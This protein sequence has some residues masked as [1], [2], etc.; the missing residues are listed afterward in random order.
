MHIYA[1]V[2]NT[3]FL[4]GVAYYLQV[5]SNKQAPNCKAL[6]WLHIHTEFQDS[7]LSCANYK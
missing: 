6:K 1:S 7:A 3:T 5:T 4:V 2:I